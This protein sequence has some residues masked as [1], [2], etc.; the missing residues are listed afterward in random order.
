MNDFRYKQKVGLWVLGVLISFLFMSILVTNSVLALEPPAV[1]EVQELRATGELN[2]RL[3][4]SRQIGNHRVDPYVLKRAITNTARKILE[5][6]GKTSEEIEAMAPL[7]APPPRWIGMPTTGNVRILAIL[8]EFQDHAH[9][10]PR[11]YIHN[12]LFGVGIPLAKPYE[13]LSRYYDRAS[14][15]QLDLSNGNTLG[16]YQTA[17]NRSAVAETRAGRQALIK[18]VLNHYDGQGHDFSQ[19]DNDGDGIIDYF[20]VIWTGPDTGWANFWWGFQHEF[21]DPGY[22]LDGVQLGKYSWQWEVQSAGQIFSPLVVIHETGHALGVPD[23]YD[24]DDSVGPDG[25]VGDLDIMDAKRGDHN[26]FS[27]WMLEWITPTVIST[28]FQTVT[29]SASGTSQ[30]CVLI[31]PGITTGDLFSEYFL[32]QNR[33][34]VGN[35]DTTGMPGDGMLIWHVDARLNATGYKFLYDNSF[36]AHKLL[37]LMEADGLEEIETGNGYGDAG[38]YY[39]QGDVFGVCTTPSSKKYDGTDSGVEINNISAP[40]LQMTARFSVTPAAEADYTVSD[41]AL[42][43]TSVDPGDTVNVTYTAK[44]I[45][46]NPTVC[47]SM[48]IF[49]SADS[50]VTTADTQLDSWGLPA[51]N[52]AACDSITETRTVTI[53]AGSA[54]GSYYIGVIADANDYETEADETNNIK[55]KE[56]TVGDTNDGWLGVFYSQVVN[57]VQLALLRNFRDSHLN[58]SESGKQYTKKLYENSH[59]ALAVLIKNPELIS[60]ARDLLQE[61]MTAIERVMNGEP[62]HLKNA[63]EIIAYLDSFGEKAP[64]ELRELAQKVKTDIIEQ[65]DKNEPFLGFELN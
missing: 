35:D 48:A 5:A 55:A 53:P 7:M 57:P 34:R 30:D 47:I 58:K 38:D 46:G 60:E 9:S 39:K 62:A 25:G 54:D 50:T 31:F 11:L 26:C 13:S 56:I 24:Y 51:C 27:K 6:Q 20:I 43:P 8:I 4:F 2:K 19:Y 32:A 59:A 61:N 63:D 21:I 14:Y 65:R 42:N 12:S 15:G 23:Y 49:L 33:H 17:Y 3:E 10:N 44:N 18:E 41:L 28:G 64:Q 45:G 1:G 16:W 22:T 29:L 40:G 36:T 37:R 52:L